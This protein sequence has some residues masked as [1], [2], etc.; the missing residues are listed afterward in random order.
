VDFKEFV[1]QEMRGGGVW[2]EL[3]VR[4]SRILPV[5]TGMS[6]IMCICL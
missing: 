2:K 5:K 1:K 3:E 4:G 6:Q